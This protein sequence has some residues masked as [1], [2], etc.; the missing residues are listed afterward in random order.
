MKSLRG[1][2]FLLFFVVCLF[3]LSRSTLSCFPF[4]AR[5]AAATIG[6]HFSIILGAWPRK[7]F[8]FGNR[9]SSLNYKFFP[10]SKQKK[11]KEIIKFY[12]MATLEMPK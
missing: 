11:E 12:F 4:L 3:I 10:P 6:S 5:I 1:S 8:Y 2:V 7:I 9:K